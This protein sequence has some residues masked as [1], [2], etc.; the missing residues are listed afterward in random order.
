[1]TSPTLCL[2][3]AFCP[4]WMMELLQKGITKNFEGLTRPHGLGWSICACHNN[5]SSFPQSWPGQQGGKK[6]IF[7]HLRY[8]KMHLGDSAAMWKRGL[9]SDKTKKSTFLDFSPTAMF[10]NRQTQITTQKT[11]YPLS[12]IVV[13]ALYCRGVSLQQGLGDH[14]GLK[15]KWM[16]QSTPKFL[17]ENL[18][19][20]ENQM[21]RSCTFQHDNDSKHTAKEQYSS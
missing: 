20:S 2:D 19:S 8:A 5:L 7:F 14:S 13:A 12:T 1:M 9:W 17:R 6:E 4:H 3:Q 18:F 11:P 16:R 10:G 21:G 15:G